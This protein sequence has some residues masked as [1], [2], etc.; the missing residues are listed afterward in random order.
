MGNI[1]QINTFEIPHITYIIS[2][3][4]SKI[5]TGLL[6]EKILLHTEQ[7]GNDNIKYTI[8]VHKNRTLSMEERHIKKDREI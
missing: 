2:K 4:N 1:S 8:Q 5:I 3:I 6:H 7:Y